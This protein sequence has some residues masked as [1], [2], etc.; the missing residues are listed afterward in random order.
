MQA[1]SSLNPDGRLL[2]GTRIVRLFA[3]GFLS[4][5]LA[6][7]LA[8]LG[9]DNVQI[10]WLLTWTLAGDAVIS[11]AIAGVADHVGRRRMLLL[12]AGLMV[13]AGMVFALTGHLFWLTLAA[14][15]GT[16]SPSGAEVG[17]FL[18]IE[19]AILPQTAPDEHR[20][21]IFAWYNLTGS[22][23]TALGAL[24][25]GGLAQSL[26]NWGQAP[27]ESYRVVVV[28]YALLGVILGT[29]F[30]R[31]SPAAEVETKL[32][33][34]R[35]PASSL[36]LG[37]HRSRTIVLKLAALF[38]LDAFAGGLVV[39]SLIA[40][41]LHLRFGVEPAGLGS[42]FFGANILAGLSALVAARVARRIGLVNTM[43]WTHIPSNILLMLVP[44]MPTLPLAVAV[45]LA[46]FSIS[47]MDVP[48]RQSYIM[49]VVDPT[50]R[51]AAA[52]ATTIARTAAVAA[53]PVL[54]GT[55]LGASLFNLPFFLAG[56]L[57]ILYDLLLYRSFKAVKPPEEK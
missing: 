16:L 29:L 11:F 2:F 15:I 46:R 49:A 42:I 20:T 6:L 52:G 5:V 3:Y 14:I 44:L 48:T 24:A 40:Y 55:L 7:Y 57:K 10:G 28:G 1:L 47:Q 30:T 9:L 4:V 25:G 38:M 8:E 32:S 36:H 22:F 23:S 51:S 34:P 53:A 35:L 50:E 13:V 37:L 18:S 21:Q 39:Q 12:G 19:Q 45:L 56:G 31:L 17:P 43:V 54:T 41:W 26:Q 27:L 33:T